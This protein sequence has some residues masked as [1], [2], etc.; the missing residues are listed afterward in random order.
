M[1]VRSSLPEAAPTGSHV[2]LSFTLA[3]VGYA[4]P[5][6]PRGLEVIFR[7]ADGTLVKRPIDINR[8]TNT[9]PR[10]WQPG[11]TESVSLAVAAPETPGDFE[12]LLNLPDPLL[13]NV[14][15][16]THKT[17]EYRAYYAVRL[18]NEGVWEADTGF[19]KLGHTLSVR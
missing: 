18:A 2:E 3:N 19:N 10:F 14:V 8:E 6:N 7:A 9:D 1:L 13:P 17:A 4:S 12:V 16:Y 11:E 15:S 5:F